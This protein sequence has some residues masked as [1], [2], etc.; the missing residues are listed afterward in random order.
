[1]KPLQ[2]PKAI[3]DGM[4]VPFAVSFQAHLEIDS[5][6]SPQALQGESFPSSV[7]S[8]YETEHCTHSEPA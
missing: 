6:L 8:G 1:M 5:A 7:L 2:Q 4:S 3:T